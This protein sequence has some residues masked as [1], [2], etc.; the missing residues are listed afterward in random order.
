MSSIFLAII[1]YVVVLV[2]AFAL[3][4]LVNQ[5][6]AQ[7]RLI[8]ERLANEQKAPERSPDEELALLRDEQL[9]DIPVLDSILRRSARVSELQTMLAQGGSI[10]CNSETR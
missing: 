2:V 4:A 5:R 10:V 8:K 7:A 6:S 3:G 9:S 1:V